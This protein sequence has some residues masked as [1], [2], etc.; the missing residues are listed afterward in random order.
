M[1]AFFGK[2]HDAPVYDGAVEQL[3]PVGAICLW[4]DEPIEEGDDGFYMPAL[5]SAH[6]WILTAQHR[7]CEMR[8]VIGS[9]A[10]QRKEC[11]CFTGDYTADERYIAELGRRGEAKAAMEE[12]LETGIQL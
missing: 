8:A 11:H 5:T 6:G 4:C 3:I 2:R 12:F 7:E 10:H 1:R 9:L